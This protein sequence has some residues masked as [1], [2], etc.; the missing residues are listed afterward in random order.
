MSDEAWAFLAYTVCCSYVVQQ[1][2]IR[3]SFQDTEVDQFLID[4][5]QSLTVYKQHGLSIAG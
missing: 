4:L 1:N 2:N 5:M 3:I